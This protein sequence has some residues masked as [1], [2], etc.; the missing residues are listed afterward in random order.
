[1]ADKNKP[2]VSREYKLMLNADRFLDRAQGSAAFQRLVGFLV[3]Q[4]EGTTSGTEDGEIT[5]RTSFLDTRDLSLHRNGFAL[6]LR[7]ES[8]GTAA[9]NLK[10]RFGDRYLSAA[11]D[12]S[13]T[14][15]DKPKFEEDIVPPFVSKFSNSNTVEMDA[16]PDLS[17]IDQVVALFPGLAK[18]EIPSGTA[19]ETINGFKAHEVVR[20]VGTIKFGGVTKSEPSLSFWY[21]LGG[22]LEFPLIVEFSFDYKMIKVNPPVPGQLEQYEPAAVEGAGRLFQELQKHTGWLNPNA[23]TKTAFAID[24]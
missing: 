1:M 15:P 8:D 5:R 14:Q 7:E 6:R 12:V 9:V 3:A 20:K 11:R 24:A 18:C 21:L 17:S 2:V 23:T 19:I 10:C 13:S 4:Q 16:A 22:D